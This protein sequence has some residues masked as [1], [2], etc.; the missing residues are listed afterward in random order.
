M[1]VE[2]NDRSDGSDSTCPQVEERRRVRA[3]RQGD[4][5]R[6][7]RQ[8]LSSADD[9]LPPLIRDLI[10]RPH[11][12]LHKRTLKNALRLL[13][14]QCEAVHRRF[15]IKKHAHCGSP[16]DS[17]EEFIQASLQEER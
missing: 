9:F 11:H 16:R 13:Q 17:L 4:L 10:S 2:F 7:P 14:A 6:K 15:I 3:S 8:L 12:G 5:S 1:S